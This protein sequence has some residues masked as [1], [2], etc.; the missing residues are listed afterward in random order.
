MGLFEESAE[1][2]MKLKKGLLS[3]NVTVKI[4][5]NSI[6]WILWKTC[7]ITPVQIKKKCKYFQSIYSL[8]SRLK[9]IVYHWILVNKR[10]DPSLND[11]N[12]R[13]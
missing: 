13:M 9:E 8:I 4:I 10:D 7:Q 1:K 2:S 11:M 6:L 12:K 5:A 3:W